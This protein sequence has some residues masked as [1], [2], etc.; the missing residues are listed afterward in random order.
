MK[1]IAVLMSTYNG[2]EYLKEQIDSIL[3]QECE[4]KIDLIVR[5]DCS[6]DNTV[7]ILKN[8]SKKLKW[9]SD[10]NLGPGASFM[11]LLYEN[12]GYDYYAF[13]DQDDFWIKEKVQKALETIRDVDDVAMYCSNAELCNEMLQPIGRKAHRSM[14]YFNKERV[15][16]GLSCAQGCTIMINNKFARLLT[17]TNTPSNIVMH[18]SFLTCLCFAVDGFFY[19]DNESYIK[20][21]AHRNN[22]CGLMTRKQVSMIKMINK[23]LNYILAS[24]KT[25]IINQLCFIKN[26]YSDSISGD[27]KII[28]DY[29]IESK[30]NFCGRLSLAIKPTIKDESLNLNIANRIKILLGNY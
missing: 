15:F 24:P 29:V 30:N 21:R 17:L 25:S 8:Y 22:V 1:K 16:L 23:R 6:N 9:Y 26:N 28:L 3:A 14:E 12:A 11:K 10:D 20:Y 7:S 18:D 4:Y 19:A 27:S 5:D 13:S 2:E